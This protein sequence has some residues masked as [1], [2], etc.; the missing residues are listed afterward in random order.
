MGAQGYESAG[1]QRLGVRPG[2]GPGRQQKRFKYENASSFLPAVTRTPGPGPGL[3]TSC[4][5]AGIPAR[6]RLDPRY[7]TAR[8]LPRHLSELREQTGHAEEGQAQA[9][10]PERI[11]Q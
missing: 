7:S 1:E 10:P 9:P 3:L 6:S 5:L 11:P 2:E 4:D 8:L